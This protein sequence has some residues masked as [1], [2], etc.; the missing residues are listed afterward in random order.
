MVAW[1]D[2][3]DDNRPICPPGSGSKLLFVSEGVDATTADTLRATMRLATPNIQPAYTRIALLTPAD[4]TDQEL[5][6]VVQRR[7]NAAGI[8][9]R[10]HR[11]V[12]VR[13]EPHDGDPVLHVHVLSA[14]RT[15]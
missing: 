11:F 10:T 8:S 5:L 2:S 13:H 4:M 12:A 6:A 7:L 3:E 1:N 14:R 15:V 9:S